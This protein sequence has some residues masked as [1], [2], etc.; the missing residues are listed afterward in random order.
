MTGGKFS[1]SSL[2][3]YGSLCLPKLFLGI[4]SLLHLQ[5]GAVSKTSVTK[6]QHS[7]AMIL[8]SHFTR[9][10]PGSA[11]TSFHGPS[12]SV[13]A[14]GGERYSHTWQTCFVRESTASF[15]QMKN[16]LSEQLAP[17]GL[18]SARDRSGKSAMPGKSQSSS[19]GAG[20]LPW[21]LHPAL[22]SMPYAL[23]LPLF[24]SFWWSAF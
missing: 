16:T 12:M 18:G 8:L 19:C 5:D 1:R 3:T 4:S 7:C 11:V 17:W 21:G 6:F 13:L 10:D 20:E 14:E 9:F 15:L 22:F 24:I 23:S 2:F